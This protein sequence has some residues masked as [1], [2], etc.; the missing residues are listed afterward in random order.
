MTTINVFQKKRTQH[1][2]GYFRRNARWFM[3]ICLMVSDFMALFVSGWVPVVIWFLYRAEPI[4]DLYRAIIPYILAFNL[5]YFLMGVYVPGISPV[6]E[7]RRLSVSTSIV[8]L[9]SLVLFLWF[10]L[11]EDFSQI[12]LIIAWAL[13]MVLVPATRTAIRR[14]L[15]RINL[16]GEPVAILG[17]GPLG[18]KL[19]TYL[20]ANPSLGF[21]PYVVIDR[22]SLVR[23]GERVDPAGIT[24]KSI[25]DVLNGGSESLVDIKT[26]ILVSPEVPSDFSESIID[27]SNF[28]FS[29]LIMV[30]VFEQNS[31]LWLQP[32]DI[33]GIIGLEVGQNLISLWQQTFKRLIDLI[34]ILISAPISIPIIGII[35]LAIAIDSK[36]PVFYGSRRVG[37]GGQPFLMWK[38]RTMIP[39]ADKILQQC[40]ENNPDM[41]EEWIQTQKIKNDP[42]VTRMG[43]ILRKLSLDE[44][45]QIWNV[46]TGQM[47]LVGPRPIPIIEKDIHSYGKKFNIYVQ[48]RPGLTGLW[49]VSGRS[50]VDYSERVQMDE[51]YVRHWSLWLDVIILA[52]TPLAVLQGHGAY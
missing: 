18:Y 7:L 22:R 50:D 39:E 10:G 2:F 12:L 52:R 37:K 6:D 43:R 3:G 51:Y 15:T 8:F 13:A 34:L 40:L 30:S 1:Q 14:I 28:K 38:F 47:S 46:V 29:R 4:P 16:W 45:P 36:G 33:G 49:Q 42:R 5:A 11:N 44:L 19:V 32:Y 35:A 27:I 31:N 25:Q 21:K 9:F 26:A 24:V 17:Y 20:F 48:V 23:R 41:M